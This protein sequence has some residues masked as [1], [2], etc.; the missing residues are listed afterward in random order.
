MATK[1]QIAA[2]KARWGGLSKGEAAAF[3]LMI[4]YNGGEAHYKSVRRY[5]QR[6]A[7]EGLLTD[8]GKQQGGPCPYTAND[9]AEERAKM[10]ADHNAR[11]TSKGH[12]LYKQ[13]CAAELEPVDEAYQEIQA[14]TH[15]Y[16]R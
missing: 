15:G 3:F 9:T 12:A 5:K 11:F 4:R 6:F 10:N 1:A 7:E 2:D 8:L 13:M 16:A 14:R